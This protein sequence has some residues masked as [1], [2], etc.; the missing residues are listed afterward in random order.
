M[1]SS[2]RTAFTLVELLVVIAIIGLLVAILLP[3]VQAA[4]EAARKAQCRNHLKQI[5]LSLH[6]FHEAHGHFPTN[7][8][9]RSWI[10]DPDRG[11][12]LD[13]PGGWA[14]SV[15]PYIE[16]TAI[17]G[18]GAGLTRPGVPVQSNPEKMEAGRQIAMSPVQTYNCPSRRPAVPFPTGEPWKFN[19]LS[20]QV[21]VLPDYAISGGDTESSDF[22]VGPETFEEG[23]NPNYDWG[24]F[25]GMGEAQTGICWLRSRVTMAKVTDGTANTYAVG[26]KYVSPDGYLVGSDWGDDNVTY[27]GHDWDQIRWSHPDLPPLQDRPGVV[28]GLI[29][30]SAH[31]GGF[32]VTMCDGSVQTISYGIDPVV[33]ARLGNRHDGKLVDLSGL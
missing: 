30:G 31:P 24:P 16:E 19:A 6:S 32:H 21:A 18:I 5:G 10:G 2:K 28:L 23:D 8:W 9:G 1:K 17:H 3:A 27:C 13:Q 7:G 14:Y 33:H 29:F 4:R 20:P 22:P 25:E 26:E 15:L 12:G 11:F